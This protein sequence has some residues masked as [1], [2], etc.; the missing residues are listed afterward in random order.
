MSGQSI[1]INFGI[2]MQFLNKIIMILND[3]FFTY[4]RFKIMK[5]SSVITFIKIIVF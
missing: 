1:C 3:L 4:Y 5:L 2:V